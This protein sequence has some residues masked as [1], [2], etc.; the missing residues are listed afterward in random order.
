MAVAPSPEDIH[1][2]VCDLSDLSDVRR[3][4]QEYDQGRSPSAKAAGANETRKLAKVD[5]LINNAGAMFHDYIESKDGLEMNFALNVAG[6][7]LLTELLL[8]TLERAEHPRVVTVASGGM[9]IAGREALAPETAQGP[10]LVKPASEPDKKTIDGQAQYAR[11]KRCQVALTEHWADKYRDSG[12]FWSVMHPGWTTT[13]GL[14]AA[15]PEFHS[16]L[17]RF[18]RPLAQ[19]ADTI[20][21]LTI[22]D[23]ALQ[24]KQAEFFLDRSPV[25]K[26]LWLAGT[27]YSRSDRDKLVVFLDGLTLQKD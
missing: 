6:T 16:T 5:A 21:W 12:I 19:G 10:D 25:P 4:A 26:H 18:L 1:L 13:P 22:A 17:K 20:V 11:N 24:H 14:E 8:P 15:M 9:L 23:E 3:F 2:W 7:Y 27:E